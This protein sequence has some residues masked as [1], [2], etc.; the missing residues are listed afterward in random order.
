MNLMFTL[1]DRIGRGAARRQTGLAAVLAVGVALVSP[2]A[3]MARGASLAWPIPLDSQSPPGAPPARVF[4]NLD[5]VLDAYESHPGS[6]APVPAAQLSPILEG[7]KLVA[8]DWIVAA[9]E[10]A[11]PHRRLTVATFV[12]EVL[13]GQ[14]DSVLWR[15]NQPA[16]VLLEWACSL[17]RKEPP[18]P[19]G[20]IGEHLWFIATIAL[21]ERSGGSSASP[22]SPQSNSKASGAVPDTGAYGAADTTVSQM[23]Q[24]HLEDAKS[25]VPDEPRWAIVQGLVEELRSWPE[26]R[27]EVALSAQPIPAA[28]TMVAYEQALGRPEVRQEALVR[29]GEFELRLGLTS[30]ALDYFH[31]AGTPTD[32][33]VLYWLRLF[34]GDALERS[35]RPT[36]AIADYRAALDVAPSAQT[37]TVALGSALMK[38]HRG[39]EG[40]TL[41]GDLLRRPPR[42]DPWTIYTFPD[43]RYFADA[44]AKLRKAVAT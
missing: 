40:A 28:A 19:P 29:L 31:Q 38:Q 2:G 17:L 1:A 13:L 44:L 35:N 22:G 34:E 24:Y 37:A 4:P 41:V 10:A 32:P 12:V 43:W 27:D 26:W 36:E 7:L 33:Y 30:K 3:D 25:R 11:V 15:K 20:D 8:P 21:M 23:L 14:S 42:P 5:K 16:Q 18:P 9:G 6:V 39:G